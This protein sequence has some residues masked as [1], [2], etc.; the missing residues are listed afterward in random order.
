MYRASHADHAQVDRAVIHCTLMYSSS[1]I[2]IDVYIRL[3]VRD[4]RDM[5]LQ[6]TLR[7][8]PAP[9]GDSLLCHVKVQPYRSR[10]D[11]RTGHQQRSDGV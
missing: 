9:S 7:R 8:S 11:V 3:D 4:L 2:Y 10:D 5:A 1:C 6:F